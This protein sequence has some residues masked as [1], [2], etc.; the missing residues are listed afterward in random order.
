MKRSRRRPLDRITSLKVKLGVLVGA[1]ILTAALVSEAG[2]RAG[3][4]AWL[5][6]PV[7]VILGLYVTQLLARGMI[8]PL[9]EMT[10]AAEQ[11]ARGDYTARVRPTTATDEVG[12]LTV[13]FNAMAAEL[14]AADGQRR[15]LIATVSHELRTPLAAQRAV[16][17]NLADGVVPADRPALETVLDQSE[18][19]SGLVES[20]LDLA[21]MEGGATALDLQPVDVDELV[22]AAVTETGLTG[23]PVDY[24]VDVDLG[25]GVLA[26]PMRVRQILDNL[27]DNATRHSPPGGLVRVRAGRVEEDWFLEVA[28]AGEGIPAERQ[29]LV[30]DRF[31][32]TAAASGGTGLGLAIARGVCDLHGGTIR[33]LNPPPGTTGAVI[34]VQLPRTPSPRP[35]A[36]DPKENQMNTS[37]EPVRPGPE[38]SAAAGETAAGV[39]VP[40]RTLPPGR[41]LPPPYPLHPRRLNS[42]GAV[43]SLFGRFWPEPGLGA[44]PGLLAAGLG[45]GLAAAVLVPGHDIG[46]GLAAAFVIAGL[47]MAWPALRRRDW[48]AAACYGL[49]AVLVSTIVLRASEEVVALSI[50]GAVGLAAVGSAAGRSALALVL[51]PLWWALAAIRGLPLL[52]RTLAALRGAPRMWAVTRTAVVSVVALIVFGG[53]FASAD[54]IFGS[55]MRAVLPDLSLDLLVLRVFVA[56]AVSGVVLAGV[57]LTLNRPAL[58]RVRVPLGSRL[59]YAWEWVVPVGVV[60]AV[61][62]VFMAAQSAAM[63]GGHEYL[64]RTTGLGYGAYVHQGFGQL[65]TATALTLGIVA[66]VAGKASRE[67]VRDRV[68]IRGVLGVLCLLTLAVVASALYR[69]ALYQ[70][71]FGYTKLRIFVDGFELWLGLIVLFAMIAGIRL[72]GAWVPRA[73]IL[74]AGILLAGF[75]LMNPDAFVAHRNIDRYEA[76]GKL[77]QRYLGG[78]SGDAVPVILS[79]LAP[80]ERACILIPARSDAGVDGPDGVLGWNLGRAR[81]YAALPHHPSLPLPE[82]C[83]QGR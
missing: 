31:G 37:D 41:A 81:M 32:T 83:H 13:A 1:S 65:T 51:A 6:V 80:A 56:V 27:L 16:L 75:G 49:G 4:P 10:A 60:I 11:M 47:V 40:T 38:P 28:D 63:W 2:T 26:D 18:R 30:F 36:R 19:L 62:V 9:R 22:T 50:L 17:E 70:Q 23:R 55:W 68:L 15:A 53:L 54:A 20:L 73:A 42:G 3:V 29:E 74:T 25:L 64:L 8:S 43:D 82:S 59:P 71:A 14:A 5:T 66:L 76:T 46:V 67:S 33:V 78:L 35:G 61:F 45:A 48:W 24:R 7:T 79:R 58:A 57:Y 44:R 52:G 77:D 39:P 72:S 12:R 21:R 34:R 69:M